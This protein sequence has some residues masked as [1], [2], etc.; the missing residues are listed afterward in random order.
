MIYIVVYKEVN[1]LTLDSWH[2]KLTLQS[3]HRNIRG[4]FSRFFL[5]I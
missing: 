1:A 4:Y 5:K 2:T 3:L